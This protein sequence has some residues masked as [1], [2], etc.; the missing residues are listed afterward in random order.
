MESGHRRTLLSELLHQRG[1]TAEEFSE[2]ANRFAYEHGIDAT[3]S[4]RHVHRLASGQRTDGRPLGP[5]RTGTKRLLEE[6]LGVPI[7]RLLKPVTS[8]PSEVQSWSGEA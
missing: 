2:Q 6:M 1:L 8:S 4:A 3:L 5:V 7:D